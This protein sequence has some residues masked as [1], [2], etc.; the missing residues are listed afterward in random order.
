MK[1]HG[2]SLAF[3]ALSVAAFAAE[4]TP[5]QQKEGSPLDNLPP[6]ITRLTHFGERADFSHDGKRVLFLEKTF[7]DVYEYDR[8]TKIIRPMTH[9]YFHHGYVRALYLANGDLLLSGAREFDPAN[10]WRSRH[11]IA[12]LWVVKKDLSGPAVPLGEKC[13]EGPAVSRKNMKI[14]WT[15]DHG[16]HPDRMPKGVSQMWQ[17]DIVYENGAPRLVNKQLILDSRDLSFQCGLEVQNFR[18]PDEK[19][20]IFSAYGYQ[21]TEVMGVGIGTKNVT[22]YSKSPSYQEPEGIFPDGQW[23]L[24]ECDNHNPK[25]SQH[26]DVYRLRL[27]GSAQA[28]RI[29]HFN[30]YQG[31]KASNPVV[32][33]DGRFI[34]FQYARVGDIAGVGHGILL[35]D[36]AAMKSGETAARVDE[37]ELAAR[38]VIGNLG[39]SRGK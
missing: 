24:M 1:T 21:G 8:D 18:P 15:L 35:L 13:S 17:G 6:Y 12:E 2:L 19:D 36:L 32:S 28:E 10:P 34:A 26:I 33:D 4:P 7:G 27:D 3:L 30:D 5:P 23:T 29:T 25:G 31:Y 16:D 9:H 22:N 38:R 14:A 39:T 20:L 37:P 11:D